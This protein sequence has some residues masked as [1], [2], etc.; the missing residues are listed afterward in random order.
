MVRGIQDLKTAQQGVFWA[1]EEVQNTPVNLIP[2]HFDFLLLFVAFTNLSPRP[3]C[4]SLNQS[5]YRVMP[6]RL[7]SDGNGRRLCHVCGLL[8]QKFSILAV[9]LMKY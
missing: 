2:Q 1:A 5:H 6:W 8:F 9:R 7:H 3:D 4:C